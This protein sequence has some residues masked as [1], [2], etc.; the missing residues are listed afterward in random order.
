MADRPK[1]G[2]V[3]ERTAASAVDGKRVH[4]LVPYNVKANLGDFTE[5]IAPGALRNTKLD[6]LVAVIDH[7]DRGL[8]LARYPRSL[9][10]EHRD[11]G[12]VWSF[13]PPTSRHDVIEA[14]SRG[15]I[16]GSSWRMRVGA[17]RWDGDHRVITQIDELRDITLAGSQQ[18]AYPTTVEYRTLNPGEAQEDK[19]GTE[20]EKNTEEVRVTNEPDPKGQLRVEDRNSNTETRSRTGFI[21][22]I[23][24]FSRDIKRGEVRSLTTAASVSNPEFSATFFDALRPQSAFLRSGVR[25]LTTDR[26]SAI[27]PIV[28]G[29]PTIGWVSEGG[30]ITPSD[31]TLVA[32]TAV[33]H[34]LSVIVR[35]S[36][37][38]AEDSSPAL[39]TVLRQVLVGRAAVSVDVAAYEGT[40]VSPQPLGM[41]NI[42]SITSFNASTTATSLAW[43][44]SAISALETANA[45]RPYA[46]VGGA[47]LAKHLRNVRVDSGGTVG[48]YAF[49]TSAEALPMIWGAEG[50]LANG[51]AGGTAYV[52][53]PSSCYVVNRTSGFDIEVDRSR[54]FNS[55]ESEM[56]LRARLDFL[57][58]FG[59][60]TAVRGTAIPA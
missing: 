42:P 29:D 36:N 4:G 16:A 24:S 47:A 60:A 2:D 57:Y 32:G 13:E 51:L 23:A 44:G 40:G 50:F 45:P 7:E 53:S 38:V 59:T 14:I 19:M 49:P 37:E 27:F 10:T 3:E 17:E 30:T 39:E 43:G 33:P 18:P 1:P 8:P 6:S 46:Y 12:L 26:D 21:D 28:S 9:R 48:P 5:E 55:D 22:E 35:Y 15:D 56:R 52:Y 41:G 54:L 31:P 25:T 58:P 20:P 11:E 34:K